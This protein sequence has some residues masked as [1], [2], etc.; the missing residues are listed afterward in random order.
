MSWTVQILRDGALEKTYELA[1]G[2]HSLGR[3]ED[4]R[5]PLVDKAVSGRHAVLLLDEK[6][7]L[8]RDADSR[9]GVLV[10]GEKISEKRFTQ[11]FEAQIG[12]YVLRVAPRTAVKRKSPGAPLRP[13]VYALL[14]ALA[15][16]I[17][18][19]NALPQQVGFADFRDR[20]VLKR[21]ILLGRYLAE[22]NTLPLQTRAYDQI[23][24][25][26]VSQEEG[27]T[28]AYVIDATGKIL[29]PA[30]DLGKSLDKPPYD[31]GLRDKTLK[32]WDG[33]KGLK[34]VFYPIKNAELFIGAAVLGY[35][36][37]RA[38]ALLDPGA[39]KWLLP[40]VFSLGCGVL[41]AFLLLRLFFRPLGRLAEE[42]GLCLKQRRDSLNYATRNP[43]FMPL[44]DACNRLLLQA[45]RPGQPGREASGAP[46]AD[47]AASAPSAPLAPDAAWCRLDLETHRVLDHNE[48]FGRLPGA[49][50]QARG[51]HLLEVFADPELLQTVSGL[52]EDTTSEAQARSGGKPPFL[53]LKRVDPA[54]QRQLTL[55]FTEAPDG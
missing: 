31:Q 36:V 46:S 27:V 7:A 44:V 40:L 11:T 51:L 47:P 24:T 28:F 55:T 22:V 38:A 42:L 26:T 8:L 21:G 13:L 18:L 14:V 48:A 30:S 15:G 41:A 52:L 45:A 29:A 37:G 12:P 17:S 50:E 19:L 34:I 5:I 53:V 35:D 10:A 1:A 3:A 39:E 9:N 32:V 33:D 43:E 49:P 16:F 20:E 2:E 6:S 54:T 25:I 4:N 23:R